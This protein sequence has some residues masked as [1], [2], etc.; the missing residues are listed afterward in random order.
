MKKTIFTLLF[1]TSLFA[2]EKATDLFNVNI[3]FIGIGVQYEKALSDNYTA[4]GTLDYIGGFKYS[5]SD[6][7]GSNFDY[8]LTTNLALEGRHYYN[9]DRRIS[10]GK[11][12]K[13]NT[14]NYVALKGT[15][16]PD[17]L[18]T[19]NTENLNLNKQGMITL[20]YG[21]KRSFSQN[22]FFEFYT[23]LGMVIYHDEYFYYYNTTNHTGKIKK[24]L[25]T[26]V[27]LDLGFRV[28]YNF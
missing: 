26:G 23:G 22:F 28:G 21:L 4:V 11:N 6:Y 27:G 17:W 24:E 18:T 1:T 14:G 10:K 25:R 2:Q 19:S 5:H 12:T 13:N 15:Y 3:S 16:T 7:F 9:F 8:I 20:N